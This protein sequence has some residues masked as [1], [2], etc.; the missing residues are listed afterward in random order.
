MGIAIPKEIEEL[1]RLYEVEVNAIEF[2]AYNSH[3]IPVLAEMNP[4]LATFL[5]EMSVHLQLER[6]PETGREL[7]L[8]AMVQWTGGEHWR[9]ASQAL[10]DFDSQ[11]WFKN[12]HRT[13]HLVSVDFRIAGGD[14]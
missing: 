7:G 4:V 6:D 1:G 10:D 5:P 8:W 14:Q 12:G 13:D 3:L 9:A 2:L 11:W